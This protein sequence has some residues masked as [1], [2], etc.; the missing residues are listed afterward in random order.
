MRSAWQATSKRSSNL[1]LGITPLCISAGLL[2]KL[3]SNTS[4][5]QL[6]TSS[7]F[8]RKRLVRVP[9]PQIFALLAA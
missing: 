9:F 1:H 5:A 6:L 8:W 3:A 7:G 2:I 4:P